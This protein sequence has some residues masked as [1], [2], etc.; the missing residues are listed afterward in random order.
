MKD[1]AMNWN[2]KSVGL[3]CRI[4]WKYNENSEVEDYECIEK[5]MG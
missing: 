5:I 2:Y 4:I 3:Q 1:I